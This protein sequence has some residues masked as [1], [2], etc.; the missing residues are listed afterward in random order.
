MMQDKIMLRGMAFYGFHG[1]SRAERTVGQPFIVDV[2]LEKALAKPGLSDNLA[3]TA[4]YS[5]A[6]RVVK[7]IIEGPSRSLLES[8]AETIASRLLAAF[9]L[10][11]VR[12]RVEKPRVPIKGVVS[13]AAVEIYRRKIKKP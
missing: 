11:A 3:D 10:E 13:S 7:E 4:D 1:T 8:L 6:Y 2:D 5:K 9:D 12:V